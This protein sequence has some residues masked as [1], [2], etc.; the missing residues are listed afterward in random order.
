[1]KCMRNTWKVA[2]WEYKRNVKNKS[3]IISTF[4]TPVIILMFTFL[5]VLF[6]GSDDSGNEETMKVY[7]QDEVGVAPT[8]ETLV[9]SQNSLAW[10]LEFTQ[11]DQ[12]SILS[13]I[14]ENENQAFLSITEDSIESG[15]VEVYTSEEVTDSFFNQLQLLSQPIQAYQFEQLGLTD[16]QI[17]QV[18]AGVSFETLDATETSSEN[19][20]VEKSGLGESGHMVPGIVSLIVLFAIVLT[21]MMIFQ[22]ASQEKKEKVS[23]IVLSSLTPSDLMQG[24]IIGYFGVGLSQ[25]FIWL[26]FGIPLAAWRIEDVAIVDNLLVPELLIMMLIA[27]L[28]YLLFAALFVGFG[29]TV[30]DISSSSNF[31]GVLM[32]LPFLPLVFIQPI[33]ISP[34][35]LAA[36]IGSFIPFASPAVLILRMALLEEWPWMEFGLAVVVLTLS[37]WGMIK[38][39]GKIF[40][41]GILLYGKN[42]TPK[43]IWKWIKA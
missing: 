21:G 19:R 3:F 28:G 11:E 34:N 7:I 27:I 38:L 12:K 32:M 36:T 30:E 13:S 31:Q 9:N 18:A 24:K 41:V 23:E 6:S 10:D 2:K 35:G 25:V 16:S 26:S 20:V 40:E 22:S 42:A 33:L 14:E 4:L 37:V 5:P 17:Q 39:S 15:V 8:V 43:E 1:M 29:S